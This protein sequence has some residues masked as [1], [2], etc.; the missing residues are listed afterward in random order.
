MK[1][2]KIIS[3]SN[4]K[5]LVNSIC[6]E[7]KSLRCLKIICPN[8]SNKTV[9][10]NDFDSEEPASY[11]KWQTRKETIE[12]KG[13]TKVCSKTVKEEI[14][15]LTKDLRE[16]S[17]IAFMKHIANMKSQYQTIDKLK[18]DLKEDEGPPTDRLMASGIDINEL[19][20]PVD[21]LRKSC[22]NIQLCCIFSINIA[23]WNIIPES[24]SAFSGTMKIHQLTWCHTE[25]D[26]IRARRLSCF[27]CNL[28]D[29]CSHYALRTKSLQVI[30]KRPIYSA[31]YSDS[32][33]ETEM[34][35]VE[36]DSISNNEIKP[37]LD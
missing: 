15:G 3:H 21:E 17:L 30:V 8:Y 28:S 16:C 27:E 26:L 7:D 37:F 33:P 12:I 4:V 1:L 5:S 14:R 23:K 10:F 9:V 24:L 2:L 35:R 32:E 25:K 18:K 36:D 20:I 22:H 13:K 19:Q 29:E 6:C 31:V 11:K 34:G